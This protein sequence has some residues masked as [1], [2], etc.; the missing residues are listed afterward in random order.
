MPIRAS[1]QSYEILVEMKESVMVK[2]SD[3]ELWNGAEAEK[4]I[5]MLFVRLTRHPRSKIAEGLRYERCYR[6]AKLEKVEPFTLLND[7]YGED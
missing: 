3:G 7:S 1:H 2:L 4:K 6:S 5:G